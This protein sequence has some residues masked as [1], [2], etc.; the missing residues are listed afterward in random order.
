MKRFVDSIFRSFCSSWYWLALVLM[1]VPWPLGAVTR[2]ILITNPYAWSENG[3]WIHFRSQQGGVQVLADHLKGF[4][5]AENFGWIQLGADGTGPYAN[6][7]AQDWGVNRDAA[8][9]LSGYAWSK[10]VGWID[11]NSF[12]NTTAARI[13]P[14]SGAFAGY[15]RSANLGW[16]A[17][18]TLMVGNIIPAVTDIAD[19]TLNEDGLKVAIALTVGDADT[20]AGSLSVTATSSNTTL[21]P[22]ANLILTGTGA[23]RK[24][25]FVTAPNQA[26]SSVVTVTA[27]SG[28][29]DDFTSTKSFHVTVAPINDAP[30]STHL[31]TAEA[32]TEDAAPFGLNKMV[33]TDVDGPTATVTVTLTLS[34][35]GAG[36]LSTATSGAVTSTFDGTI[37]KASGLL[38]DVNALLAGLTFTPAANWDKHF[39]IT[40]SVSDGI[41]APVTGSKSFTVTPVNDAPV[42]TEGSFSTNEDT[43]YEGIL[44]AS[45]AEGNPLTYSIVTAPTKGTVKITNPATGAFSYT[46]NLN[47]N[48][49]DSFTF[50]VYDGTSYSNTATMTVAITS[51]NDPPTITGTPPTK[52]TPGVL[53]S[54]KPVAKDVEGDTMTF[55]IQNKPSWATFNAN[56]GT[57]SGT[58]ETKNFGV[59]QDSVI[60]VTSGT[61]TVALPAFSILVEDIANPVAV[62]LP[63]GIF[64]T[65]Q[66]VTLTCQDDGSGCEAIYYTLD[67]STP[68]TGSS[69]Y[70]GT[71]S[72]TASTTLKYIAV[73][74]S[75]R[76]SEVRTTH[77]TIDANPPRI[78]I[79]APVDGASLTG[80][81]SIAGTSA[82]ESG[83]GVASI[84][85]QITD[86]AS[87]LENRPAT[88]LNWYPASWYAKDA[89][90]WVTLPAQD[91]ANWAYMPNI[92]WSIGATYTVTARATDKAGNVAEQTILFAVSLDGVKAYTMIS[93]ELS[94][95]AVLQGKTLDVTGKLT[96]LPETSMSLAGREI[97]LA[98]TDPQGVIV[99][100]AT[101]HTTDKD[102]HFIFRGVGDF[103][104]KGRHTVEISFA[105]TA[106]LNAS[107][108]VNSS[109][110]VGQSAGY[111]VIVQGRISNNE[112]LAS[113]NKTTNR[114]YQQLLNRGFEKERIFYFNHDPTQAGV[115]A[116]P[117]KAVVEQVISGTHPTFQLASLIN[118]SPA[119]VYFFLVDHGQIDKFYLNGDDETITPQDLQT[120]LTRLE[121]QLTLGKDEK[122]VVIVG[123]CYSGSFLPVV[124]GPGRV[125]ITSAAANEE[126]YKGPQEDDGVRSGEYFLE[127]LIKQWGRGNSLYQAFGEGVRQTSIYTK[128]RS[129]LPNAVQSFL[130]NAAQHPLLDDNGDKKGSNQLSTQSS[131]D[132]RVASGMF[133]GTGVSYNTNS[134]QN[135]AEV[136]AVTET[137][138]L[139]P[140][141]EVATLWAKAN[142]DSQVRSAWIEIRKPSTTLIAK[143]GSQQLEL[144]LDRFLLDSPVNGRWSVNL[145]GKFKFSDP[146]FYEI[147]Y[148]MRDL[149]SGDISPMMRSLVYK[150]KANNTAPA[151]FA[152]LSPA[153]D[154]KTKSV[155]LFNWHP[156]TDTEG[157]TYNLI[158]A[159]DSGFAEVIYR[160][161]EIQSPAAFVDETAQLAD[162]T[163]YYWKVQAVDAFGAVTNSQEAWSFKTDNTNGIPGILYGM[164]R[165]GD[166]TPV[167]N[168]VVKVNDTMV[169]TGAD[170]RYMLLTEPGT[171]AVSGGQTS[172]QSSDVTFLEIKGGK[173]MRINITLNA[174]SSPT[175]KVLDV[176]KSGAV[177]A[178]DGVLILRR[179]NG[180]STLDTGVVL[181]TGQTNAT[182]L[183]TIDTLGLALDV[184]QSGSMDATDGVLILRRLTGGSTI[185][186][187]VILPTGQSNGTVVST[188]DRLK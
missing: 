31:N 157:V 83:S 155:V 146:G 49:S 164:V 77:F 165:K 134:L 68:T 187:G 63:D 100:T 21:L 154:A 18:D 124:S 74:K 118:G 26:G 120:W 147:Y 102:G 50:K 153:K 181:P 101:T 48:G 116:K 58:P 14:T 12:D 32:F 177:D 4:A 43:V 171:V 87:Y 178:T 185:D 137:L 61:D 52:A 130:D 179:L 161:E 79:T 145:T 107:K 96:R 46:P 59:Y 162:L 72:V 38:A 184:D 30:T 40:T 70:S 174:F 17:L 113:H 23:S 36:K 56:N 8:G 103:K 22:N 85:L 57:L 35:A 144:D 89:L 132:G 82:D 188:I 41:A 149:V 28:A 133:L 95:Q 73:D 15:A 33:V 11:F 150:Q 119:P 65:A 156:S 3:G 186:T 125:V 158:I 136:T 159:K 128:Q 6:T 138:Y 163:T 148:Y 16:I 29:P 167:V 166:S 67:G 13:D 78:A 106:L 143:G 75:G 104:Q 24:L 93:M 112:G 39:T 123:A 94:S 129:G 126:S 114:I 99:T 131:G 110:L 84:Q 76:I 109:V 20:P 176:D 172:V 7:N 91:Y 182:L 55:S 141:E 140:T 142:D 98:I 44:A 71:I 117:T 105:G 51:V 121:A 88:G 160:Q 10:N 108:P 168:A 180:A 25:E 54:F 139:G 111:A 92:T 2:G 122:R 42:A 115:D 80:V 81:T 69:R 66:S 64:K 173:A 169:Q 183:T 9:R 170:G 47:L 5:W 53:Y 37:W 45:D 90:P 97:K 151:S 62:A 135:P 27:T 175:T 127:E 1:L 19:Q 34:H 152:L 86:G 60:A